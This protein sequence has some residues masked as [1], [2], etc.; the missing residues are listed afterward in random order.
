MTWAPGG[1]FSSENGLQI[2]SPRK[3]LKKLGGIQIHVPSVL[4][5]GVIPYKKPTI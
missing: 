4:Y 5:R 1:V 2:T 3:V